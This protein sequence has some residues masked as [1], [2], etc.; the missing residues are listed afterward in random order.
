MHAYGRFALAVLVLG[1]G[2]ALYWPSLRFPVFFDDIYLFNQNGLNRI[3]LAGF[4]SHPR[5]LP[6]FLTA[7]VDL[8]FDDNI[9]AQRVVNLA[10]HA[11]TAYMLYVLVKQVADRVAPHVYNGRAAL[12]AALIFLLHPLA[13][14]AVG[15]L[16]QR[17]IL[18]ATL[19]GILSLSTWFDGLTTRKQGYFLFSAL[20]YLLS[21]FSKEHA[22]LL[23]AA[24][25]AM[26]PLAAP[27]TRD[28]LRVVAWPFALQCAIALLVVIK[29]QIGAGS[30]YEPFA[31]DI[32]N[33]TGLA[34]SPAMLWLLSAI[35]QCGLYFK[36]LLLVAVPNPDWMS[37]DMR[38]PFATDWRQPM[39]LI[40]L[41]AL[42]A[43][44][45]IAARWLVQG[46]RRALA[47]YALLAPLL[48]FAVEFSVVRIQEPF[49]LYRA[50]L[51][52]PM[53]LLLLPALTQSL[54]NR[55]FWGGLLVVAVALALAASDRLKSFSSSYALWDDAVRKL[56][57]GSSPG[58][59]R[60]YNNRCQQFALRGELQAAIIDCNRAIE[61]NPS[62]KLAYRTRAHTYLRLGNFQAAIQ[63]AQTLVHRYPDDPHSRGFLGIIYKGAGRFDEAKANFEIGCEKQSISACFELEVLKT[64]Q[65]KLAR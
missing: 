37:I 59:V 2:C 39:Y 42:A 32:V 24:A 19:F 27:P 11:T 40:A 6:Y 15:Y 34:V 48:L 52:M 43:Q 49:V 65:P 22:V 3:F 20:F 31:D 60:A 36:Y 33:A 41:I 61:V 64:L 46:G 38:P 47:G 28:I 44:G 23:P 55:V 57:E 4:T 26:T 14:Y 50:Y 29:V 8:L 17:T 63:D 35:T 58:S 54:S 9:F 12:A 45:L 30:L 56:S 21:V 5:W 7:W 18:M 53:L 10:L 25:L 51:W 1:A 62:Y 16:A 13:V